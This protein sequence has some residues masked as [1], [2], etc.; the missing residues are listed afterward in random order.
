MSGSQDKA[1][2]VLQGFYMAPLHSPLH[3]LS[4]SLSL[5]PYRHSSRLAGKATSFMMCAFDSIRKVVTCICCCILFIIFILY[6]YIKYFEK[7][8][9]SFSGKFIKLQKLPPIKPPN[10]FREMNLIQLYLSID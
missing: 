5:S 2:L 10:R 3:T 4:L 1:W 8:S 7:V 9:S 6:I